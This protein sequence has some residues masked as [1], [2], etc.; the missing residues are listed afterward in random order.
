MNFENI[1]DLINAL[2]EDKVH[3]LFLE[4]IEYLHINSLKYDVIDTCINITENSTTQ[5]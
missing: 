1:K 2:G 5:L 4:Y 3:E